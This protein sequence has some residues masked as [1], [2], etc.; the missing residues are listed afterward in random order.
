M[1]EADMAESQDR[2]SLGNV[3]RHFQTLAIT[4]ISAGV[5]FAGNYFFTDKESKAV[6]LTNVAHLTRQIDEMRI[7]VR[8]M[9]AEQASKVQ[10]AEM[11]LRLRELERV[12][13][14]RGMRRG[15]QP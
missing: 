4:F 3:E 5:L 15:R 11:E 7:D 14:E 10:V 9:R 13:D 1:K 6:L 2:R 8:T 12:V